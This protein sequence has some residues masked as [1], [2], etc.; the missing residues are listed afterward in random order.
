MAETAQKRTDELTAGDR[1]VLNRGRIVRTVKTAR[2]NGYVNYR[3]EP[4]W[5]VM[6]T[7]PATPGVWSDGNS[8]NQ[9]GMWTVEVPA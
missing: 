5:N 9:S 6:Y 4:L 8:S 7:E 3:N 1:V 2:P